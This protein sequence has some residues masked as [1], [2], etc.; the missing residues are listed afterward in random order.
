MISRP[1]IGAG[2]AAL[3]FA[4]LAG[5]VAEGRTFAFDAAVRAYVHQH[6]SPGL[7]AFMRA[8]S[9][10]GEPASLIVM[11]AVVVFALLAEHWE[12]AAARFAI[13][14]VGAFVLDTSLKL[15]FHRARPVS[16]F[17]TLL[18]NSYSF[19]SG[20]ALFSIS[21]FGTLAALV[22]ARIGNPAAR[23]VIWATAAVM[24]FLIGLS[25]IY[26]GVHYPSDVIAG[27]AAA[28]VWVSAVAYVDRRLF[29][30]RHA[31]VDRRATR[32]KRRA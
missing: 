8:V 28:V 32:D 16:F 20:H 9:G 30:Q 22:T 1:A 24:A 4:W 12:R 26:L 14:M 3:I 31:A 23:I 10:I 17:G 11:S 15:A 21:F 2:V 27:Y 29:N 7:T 6:A 19:P 25:R 13:T 18:P 5:R